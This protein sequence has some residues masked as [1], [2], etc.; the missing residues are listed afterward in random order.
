MVIKIGQLNLQGFSDIKE[1]PLPVLRDKSE[2][3]QVKYDKYMPQHLVEGMGRFS[4]FR[5]L[6][7]KIQNHYKRS[8]QSTKV[9]TIIYENSIMRATF[10]PEYGGRLYSLYNKALNR[11]LLSVNPVFQPANLANRNA[12]FSG[13][14]EW[15]VGH[16]GHSFL[17]CE[18]VFFAVCKNENGEE[19]LRLYEYERVKKVFYQIDFY[20]QKDADYLA[21]YVKIVNPYEEETSIYYWSN[22][23]VSELNKARVF[24]ATKDVV[25]IKPQIGEGGITEN[26]MSYGQLPELKGIEGDVSYPRNFKWSNEY[27]F[28]NKDDLEYPWEAVGYDDGSLFFECSTQPLTYRKMFCWGTHKGGTKWQKYLSHDSDER[29]VEIQAG[30]FPTQLHSDVFKASSSIE[31]MQI[32]GLKNVENTDLVYREHD[33]ATRYVY[34]EIFTK[35]WTDKVDGLQSDMKDMAKMPIG[36]ILN[37]GRGWGALELKRAKEEGQSIELPTM[38]FPNDSMDAEQQYWLDLLEGKQNKSVEYDFNNATP[39]YMI[40]INW[41]KYIEDAI[42]EEKCKIVLERHLLN[43]A[44]ILSENHMDD[45]A[46]DVLKS[47]IYKE[48]SS[49]Y[50]RT[51]GSLLIKVKKH[52]DALVYYNEAYDKLE[53]VNIEFFEEDFVGEYMQLLLKLEKASIVWGIYQNR[54]SA[55]KNVTEEMLLYVGQAAAKLGHWETIDEIVKNIK[56]EHV[57]EGDTSLVELWFKKQAHDRGDI[58]LEKA[59]HTLNPPD[60]IDFRMI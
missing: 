59:R 20:L 40:D 7:Y 46:L 17:T 41:I 19:F 28:Q 29:Y 45:E 47:H 31:F 26:I 58:T 16:Y 8:T 60:D 34:D 38:D 39:T 12:W 6:P 53:D 15:N 24:S 49:M 55:A 22:I 57:R 56:L 37:K 2:H 48:S 52:E 13:G 43:K 18:P 35:E 25:Y 21:T 54:I 50:L 32:F 44:I 4:G 1:G 30:I 10:L 27:F 3:L 51:L 23:A 9:K 42:K 36:I 33:E 5:V 11:E 14:V